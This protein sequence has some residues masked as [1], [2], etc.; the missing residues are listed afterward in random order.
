MCA[1]SYLYPSICL[2]LSVSV[3]VVGVLERV[4]WQE[5]GPQMGSMIVEHPES[6]LLPSKP[7]LQT[8]ASLTF[9]AHQ[10]IKAPA[11][12][13]PATIRQVDRR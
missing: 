4:V 1:C 10:T 11:Y 7:A 6:L 12:E 9:P 5:M 2:C 8:Q 13:P 3:S